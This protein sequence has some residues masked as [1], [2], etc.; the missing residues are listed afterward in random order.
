MAGWLPAFLCQRHLGTRVSPRRVAVAS[1]GAALFLLDSLILT[2]WP[3]DSKMFMAAALALQG[4]GALDLFMPGDLFSPVEKEKQEPPD[5][6]NTAAAQLFRFLTG[7]TATTYWVGVLKMAR[8]K[9]VLCRARFALAVSLS[10]ASPAHSRLTTPS[11]PHPAVCRQAHAASGLKTR[12]IAASSSPSRAIADAVSR[13]GA[14]AFI[15]LDLFAL[16]LG[17]LLFVALE[18]AFPQTKRNVAVVLATF[19]RRSFVC[20]PGAAFA[21]TLAERE[22]LMGREAVTAAEAAR[23]GGGGASTHAT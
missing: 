22:V 6:G 2:E 21:A 3:T 4:I 9:R 23:L 20:G 1:I 5:A 16:Y 17:A 12:G 19:V 18:G 10:L 13:H 15:S 7:A 14:A 8:A 11:P